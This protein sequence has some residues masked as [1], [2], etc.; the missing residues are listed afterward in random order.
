MNTLLLCLTHVF[1][2]LLF[3]H[4]K[5]DQFKLSTRE[6]EKKNSS[7]RK[8]CQLFKHHF[9]MPNIYQTDE[10]KNSS[11]FRLKCESATSFSKI[12]I[13][14][15]SNWNRKMHV[16]SMCKLIKWKNVWVFSFCFAFEVIGQETFGNIYTQMDGL[17]KL[18]L[19]LKIKITH[20][21]KHSETETIINIFS[22]KCAKTLFFHYAMIDVCIFAF[23]SLSIF[24]F[25]SSKI[26]SFD[27]WTLM[28]R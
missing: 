16:S 14:H 15:A 23:I 2:F 17:Q 20:S 26:I 9:S 7:R 24:I 6:E 27:K 10:K 13:A 8:K 3:Q 4:C 19:K 18:F 12:K 22:F 5:L 1:F 28:M 21:F 11:L 25:T